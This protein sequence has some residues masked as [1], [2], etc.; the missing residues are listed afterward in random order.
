[1][2]PTSLQG[3]WSVG[4]EAA[5]PNLLFCSLGAEI[6][7]RCE[8]SDTSSVGSCGGTAT[9][10]LRTRRVRAPWPTTIVHWRLSGRSA[11][12]NAAF[13][14]L[15]HRDRTEFRGAPVEQVAVAID[16]AKIGGL[17]R[18]NMDDF[19][20]DITAGADGARCS[21]ILP[22]GVIST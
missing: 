12:R 15:W 7:G 4:H 17:D 1:M 13:A 14:C 3:R 11:F 20:Y 16:G 8:A 6:W 19:G 5:T 9:M 2:Q 21:M 18:G 10:R 22:A